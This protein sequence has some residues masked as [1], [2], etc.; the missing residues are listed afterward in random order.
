MINEKFWTRAEKSKQKERDLNN[1]QNTIEEEG[2][3]VDLLLI[4]YKLSNI[5]GK[6]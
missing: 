1:I 4:M 6:N 3:N 5:I 2:E